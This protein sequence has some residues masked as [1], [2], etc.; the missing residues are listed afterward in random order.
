MDDFMRPAVTRGIWI[1]SAAAG[2]I[3]LTGLPTIRVGSKERQR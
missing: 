3:L 2:L 1:A